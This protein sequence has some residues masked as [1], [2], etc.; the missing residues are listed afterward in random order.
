MKATNVLAVLLVGSLA[1]ACATG[2][3]KVSR[4]EFEDIPV[5]RGLTFVEDRAT[6]IESPSVKAARLYYRG[7]IE[8]NSLGVAMRTTLEANGWRSVSNTTNGSHGITQ[9]FEKNAN[10]LQVRLWEGWW[11]TYVE[12]TASRALQT[13][14]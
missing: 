1:A 11:F 5:P 14:K 9:V 12:L 6:V 7:R 2:Q 3:S 13:A 4:S 10:S 8:L